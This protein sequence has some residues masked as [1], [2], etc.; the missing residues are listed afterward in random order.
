[1]VVSFF[2]EGKPQG[3]ARP[4]FAKGRA[5]TPKTTVEYERKIA[6][7]YSGDM[8][9]G[10]L[11]L[12]ITA[13]FGVPK[14]YTKKQKEA[15]KNGVLPNKKPDADNIAKVVLDAL[16]GVAYED[17]KQVVEL[18]VS[19]LYSFEKEGIEIQIGEL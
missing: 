2:V 4:R 16:N 12:D 8:L 6:G 13:Y 18:R 1:M 14:S 15:I 11:W 10:S 5:Y 7:A 9:C 3:K 19:K 17:D